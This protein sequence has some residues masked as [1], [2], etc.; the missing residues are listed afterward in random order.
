MKDQIA[1]NSLD[2]VDTIERTADL[3]IFICSPPGPDFC[4]QWHRT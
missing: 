4:G 1:F 3:A 2:L